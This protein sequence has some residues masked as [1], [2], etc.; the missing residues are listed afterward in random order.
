MGLKTAKPGCY[1]VLCRQ[2]FFQKIASCGDYKTVIDALK[3]CQE[4]LLLLPADKLWVVDDQGVKLTR[5]SGT[6]FY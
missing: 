6:R 4:H 3:Y 2:E 1:R 5:F